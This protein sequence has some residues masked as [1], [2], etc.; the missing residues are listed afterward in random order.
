MEAF[1]AGKDLKLAV[2][3]K[4]QDHHPEAHGRGQPRN[5]GSSTWPSATIRDEARAKMP[6]NVISVRPCT[7]WC[8]GGGITR[9]SGPSLSG[10]RAGCGLTTSREALDI[11][12]V[13]AYVVKAT[14]ENFLR[15]NLAPAPPSMVPPQYR[16][17]LRR[18]AQETTRS[19]EQEIL[20]PPATLGA[21][22][23]PL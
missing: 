16:G 13:E 1:L 10:Q 17:G 18:K 9:P 4:R 5:P 20:G 14:L 6:P 21:D 2:A 3:R 8:L 11:G 22:A 7:A 19:P 23:G 15:S 12:V